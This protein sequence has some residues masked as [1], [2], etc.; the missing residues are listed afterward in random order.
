MILIAIL[1]QCA[2]IFMLCCSFVL[3]KLIDLWLHW[4][5][6]LVHVTCMTPLCACVFCVTLALHTIIYTH[7]LS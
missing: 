5:V 3:S 7:H 1:W 2:I 4:L 6:T